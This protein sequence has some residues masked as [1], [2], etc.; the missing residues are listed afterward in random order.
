MPHLTPFS[1][2]KTSATPIRTRRESRR[3]AARNAVPSDAACRCKFN[4]CYLN[5]RIARGR[6]HLYD[7][8]TENH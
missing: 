1:I 6:R 2:F 5:L 3:L 8:N 7:A 4:A